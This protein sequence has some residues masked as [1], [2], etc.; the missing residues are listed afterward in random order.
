MNFRI[1][2][3]MCV[4]TLLSSL[5]LF[6]FFLVGSFCNSVEGQDKPNIVLINLDDADAELFELRNSS[7]WFPNIMGLGQDGLR[8]N[9]FHV[10]TPL[11]GPSR[12][13]LYRGQY[14]SSTG[15]Y[16]NQSNLR[17]SH[18]F[19]GG[20]K[21]YREQGYFKDD[22]S[23]WMQGAGYR[24][25]LVG[26]FLHHD[27]ERYVP[28]GW[29]DYYV[30]RGARYYGS[31]TFTNRDSANGLSGQL[32][33]DLYRTTSET[34][35]AIELIG[36]HLARENGKPF[37]LNINPIGPHRGQVSHPEMIDRRMRNWW[38]GIRRPYSPAYDEED[39]SDKKGFFADQPRIKKHLHSEARK[40][41]RERVLATRS[42]DDMVGRILE[43]LETLGI[44]DNT[45]VIVTSDNGFLL[46]H[47]RVF[48]KG[49][50]ADRSTR[51]PLFV[52]GPSVPAGQVAKQLVG[53]I[54][55]APTLVELAGGRAPAWVDGISFADMLTR[56][57]FEQ[58]KDFRSALLIEN[59]FDINNMGNSA[60]AASNSLRLS[61][62]MY[63]EWANGDKDFF[64][65]ASD[66]NQLTNRYDELDLIDQVVLE[67]WMKSMKNPVK[68]AKARFT[69]PFVAREDLAHGG[70]LFGLAEDPVGVKQVKLQIYH[71]QS[72]RYWNGVTWQ[73][74]PV[75]INAELDGPDQ[76]LTFWRFSLAR[77]MSMDLKGIISVSAWALDREGQFAKPSR[78]SFQF[79]N[80]FPTVV[81]NSPRPGAVVNG[82]SVIRGTASDNVEVAKVNVLIR[83]LTSN[84]Y[85]NGQELQSRR[86]FLSV[87]PDWRG[88]WQYVANLPVGSYGTRVVAEDTSG[89]VS[90]ERVG[91][92][93]TVEE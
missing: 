2:G 32:P 14:A 48:G 41:F 68:L 54:D 57:G 27:F 58:T 18:H 43:S 73:T 69:A 91:R 93:F 13:C 12:A 66:P 11:C 85:W 3:L 74:D 37:F 53:H 31:Y 26:K 44:D 72:R 64:D 25:M 47:H 42:V 8:F 62:A 7:H 82:E 60:P 46:G 5:F 9:N 20:F 83:D 90:Q 52:K 4:P 29:D 67:A 36:Q 84:Q 76:Q 70:E 34:R 79:D 81:L 16:V 65:F 28:P 39:I 77:E 10:T 22:L 35:D 71:H 30:Y 38:R 61:T 86:T 24:T 15:F 49:M 88:N 75:L 40:H 45:Y 1:P 23:T 87:D 80:E 50:P 33:E 56:D 21:F 55:L 89:N 92:R 19:E 59:W 63:T 17:E 51:V 6:L 78:A